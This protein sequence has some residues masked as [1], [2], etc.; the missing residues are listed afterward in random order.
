MDKLEFV[1]FDE[2]FEKEPTTIGNGQSEIDDKRDIFIAEN[3]LD[4]LPE[5]VFPKKIEGNLRIL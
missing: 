1:P 2:R 3:A 5:P 4:Y